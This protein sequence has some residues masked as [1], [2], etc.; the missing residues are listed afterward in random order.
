[1]KNNLFLHGNHLSGSDIVLVVTGVIASLAIIVLTVILIVR[2]IKMKKIKQSDEEVK[3]EVVTKASDLAKKLGSSENI[4]KIENHS[5]RV[6]VYVKDMSLVNKDEINTVL[7]NVMYMNNKI[8]FVIGSHGEEFKTLLE[9]N[10]D[11]VSK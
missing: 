1:M 9:E 7:D 5:S 4:E 2:H 11:K 8:V 10:I 3:K 6:V